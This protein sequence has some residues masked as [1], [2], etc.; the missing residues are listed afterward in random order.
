VICLCI[1]NDAGS[2]IVAIV[3]VEMDQRSLWHLVIEQNIVLQTAGECRKQGAWKACE[4]TTA[5]HARAC[6]RATGAETLWAM[7]VL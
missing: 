7:D 5:L 6:H 1:F 3:G 2:L 4:H